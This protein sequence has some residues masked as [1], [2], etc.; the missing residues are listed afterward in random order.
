MPKDFS[1]TRSVGGSELSLRE[2]DRIAA[3]QSAAEDGAGLRGG[4][5]LSGGG[6]G[7]KPP[8]R[9]S[10]ASLGAAASEAGALGDSWGRGLGAALTLPSAGAEAGPAGGA[11][12]RERPAV[13]R[14]PP[15]L[16][17]SSGRDDAGA[18]AGAE[19]PGAAG[20]AGADAAAAERD[21]P[22]RGGH[23]GQVW[24]TISR[25]SGQVRRAG[26]KTA[27][28][29]LV[30]GSQAPVGRWNTHGQ[31]EEEEPLPE[32]EVPSTLQQ[33]PPGDLT[34]VR[35][36]GRG[37]FGAVWH[38]RWRGVDVAVK[39]LHGVGVSARTEMIRE[40]ATLATLRHPCVVGFFG[41][42]LSDGLSATV[43]E[44]VR[45]GNLKKALQTRVRRDGRLRDGSRLR[46]LC[47][48]IALSA[49]RGM[50]YLHSQSIVHF[51]LK[52]DNLLCDLR[53]L[54]NPVVKVGD[55]GLSQQK[56]ATFVSGKMRGTIPWMAPEL[57]GPMA[58]D[59]T[60][61]G[62]G[63]GNA[64][65]SPKDEHGD[66]G[67]TEKVDVFS[68]GVT[69]WEIWTLGETPYSGVPIPKV[70]QGVMG[71]TLRPEVPA[72]CD[73]GWAS[74][75]QRCWHNRA[76]SRPS[77]SEICRELETMVSLCDATADDAGDE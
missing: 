38:E 58:R 27:L 22:E 32:P 35:E 21:E 40:A 52:A 6:G 55:L 28:P 43:L 29:M 57:F 3:S 67:V 26:D 75:M 69:M 46:R 17:L 18:G 33:I 63:S 7:F 16:T 36:L 30:V 19:G 77:F 48:Q 59:L 72:D 10:T 64:S 11:E 24:E 61:E 45:D 71:G 39:E 70:L 66:G 65:D 20:A 4:G 5:R 2:M 73:A 53:D 76:P 14:R 47:L 25:Q 56:A 34:K 13:V 41:I 42:I 31:W 62:E 68:F 74:L 49:A 50:E 12:E 54:G 23:A 44:F 15:R 60:A 9:L 8:T 51:D 37:Q 1:E